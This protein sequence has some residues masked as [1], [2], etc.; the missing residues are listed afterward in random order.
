MAIP[1]HQLEFTE[2]AS[3]NLWLVAH[4][5]ERLHVVFRTHEHVALVAVYSYVLSFTETIRL[6]TASSIGS[7]FAKNIRGMPFEKR[8]VPRPSLVVR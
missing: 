4:D 8:F 5:G 3:S 6:L 1:F 7:H 2:V